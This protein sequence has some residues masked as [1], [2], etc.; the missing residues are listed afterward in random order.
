MISDGYNKFAQ[1]GEERI[2]Y[3]PALRHERIDLF[4][5]CSFLSEHESFAILNEELSHRI[6]SSFEA[7]IDSPLWWAALRCVL[8]QEP[9]T[10]ENDD[11]RNLSEGV[12]LH[13]QFP[14]LTTLGCETCKTWWVDPLTGE[15]TERGGKPMLRPPEAVLLCETRSG[16]PK[17]TPDAPKTLSPQNQQALRHYL[18]CKATHSF[19]EDAIVKHNAVIIEKGLYRA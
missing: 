2:E 9:K 18:E 3:R 8:G 11:A 19:P 12:R 6:L 16:C 15:V 5:R 17:G 7:K 4:R 13:A 10:T 1:I 14:F